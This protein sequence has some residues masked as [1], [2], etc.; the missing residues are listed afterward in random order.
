MK[1]IKRLKSRGLNEVG[2]VG[3]TRVRQVEPKGRGLG[4]TD[5][6]QSRTYQAYLVSNQ[7]S[8]KNNVFEDG[9]FCKKYNPEQNSRQDDSWL[10][11]I[12]L[13]HIGGLIKN[14]NS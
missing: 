6:G 10:A 2:Q 1:Y 5:V 12:R 3:R 13:N 7:Q 11:K 4:E 8:D 9:I 14:N